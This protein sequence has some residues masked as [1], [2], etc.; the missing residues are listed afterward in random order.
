MDVLAEFLSNHEPIVEPHALADGCALGDWRVTAYLGKGGSGEVYQVENLTSGKIAA[1]KVLVRM[2]AAAQERF[3]REEEVLALAESPALPRY[4]TSGEAGGLPYVVMELLDRRALPAADAEVAAYMLSVCAGM[5]ELHRLGFVHRDI[6]PANVL[7]RANGSPVLIDFGLAKRIEPMSATAD[8]TVSVVDGRA[9]GVGT[10]RY[11]A[12]E[13]FN[14]GEVSPATD[15]HALGM[16]ANECFAGCPPSVWRTIVRRS[17]SSI[18]AQ[19]YASVAEFVR[20]VRRRHWLRRALKIAAGL[21]ALAGMVAMVVWALKSELPQR[22]DLN[23][24]VRVEIEPVRLKGG[25]TYEIVGPGTFDADISGPTNVTLRLKNCVLLNRTKCP[26]P[27]NGIRY[28]LEDGVYLNFINMPQEP[29]GVRR[30]DFIAPYDGA[31]NDVRFGG[32][33][34]ISGLRQLKNAEWYESLRDE[35]K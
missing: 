33:D 32:P 3:R 20:A 14:G 4:H 8:D 21:I 35:R 22:I 19:R 26:F 34:T 15:I 5:A 1:A 29:S 13:Q 9:V 25:R 2:D 24:Q 30:R 18:P 7:F 31:F 11:A 12:P 16:L 23:G 17:T 10:P 28:V 27:K 6:K